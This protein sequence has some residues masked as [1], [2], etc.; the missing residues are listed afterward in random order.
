MGKKPAHLPQR[1]EITFLVTYIL[2][3][4]KTPSC[5]LADSLLGMLLRVCCQEESVNLHTEH[6][7]K[8][9]SAKRENSASDGVVSKQRFLSL[10][11]FTL[12]ST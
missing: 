10:C 9:A 7:P 3:S 11:A 12:L 4:V 8:L 6:S 5:S 2:L 1:M